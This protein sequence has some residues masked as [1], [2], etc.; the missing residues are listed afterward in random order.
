MM[1]KII[2]VSAVV[3]FV[4]VGACLIFWR[5]T[6]FAY[7]GVVEAIEVD[8]PARLSDTIETLPVQEGSPVK[9]GE[10]LARLECKDVALQYAIAQKEFERAEKLLK[11]TAGS[12]ENYD[13]KKHQFDQAALHKSWCLIKS[14]LTGKVLYKYYEAGEFIP[15]GRKL[16]TVADLNRLDVWVYVEHDMLARLQIGMKVEGFLPE[17]GQTF[18]GVI[19]SINDEA[20]F[21]PKNVQ[22]RRER[23]RL[24]YGVKT[25]FENDAKQTLKPGMTLEVSFPQEAR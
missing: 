20:E 11:T 3:L 19:L 25:R 24:V 5:H 2:A 1:K 23:E 17:T 22:T 6:P 9:E 16:L 15:A 18:Q 7:S 12:R 13:L 8:V 10:E 21:T 4:L 14:P